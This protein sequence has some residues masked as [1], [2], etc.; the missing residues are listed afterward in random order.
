MSR[1]PCRA[2]QTT[3]F[4][5]CTDPADA[6]AA[7]PPFDVTTKATRTTKRRLGPL[8]ALVRFVVQKGRRFAAKSVKS[9][10]SGVQP[11]YL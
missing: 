11:P 8:V 6:P 2:D 3:D 1:P 4:T 10:K 9:V 5:D 7:Q